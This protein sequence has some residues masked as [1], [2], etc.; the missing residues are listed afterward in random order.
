MKIVATVKTDTT[1]REEVG[2][3]HSNGALILKGGVGGE[4]FVIGGYW[5][6]YAASKVQYDLWKKDST[7]ILY[8]TDSVE[9]SFQ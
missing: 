8:S 1:P 9:L 4:P 7:K 2:F 6:N 3:I 5:G